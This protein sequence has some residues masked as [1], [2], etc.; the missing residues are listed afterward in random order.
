MA[1][2]A[3]WK[4]SIGFGMAH[5]PVKLMTATRDQEPKFKR[6]HAPTKSYPN[7]VQMVNGEIVPLAVMTSVYDTGTALVE[8]T[9]EDLLTVA[10]VSKR[11]MQVMEFVPRSNIDP[12]YIE[13]T[14]FLQSDDADYAFALMA[15]ALEKR[16]VAAIVRVMMRTKEYL[17]MIYVDRGTVRL[18]TMFYDAEIVADN[19]VYFS[20]C[21]SEIPALTDDAV[22]TA[23]ALVDAY[24]NDEFN[25]AKYKD[26]YSMRLL[27]MIEK[28]EAG[29]KVE[30]TMLP[31]APKGDIL[32]T[33]RTQLEAMREE[34]AA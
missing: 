19:G 27:E 16:D 23:C 2:K 6:W 29:V 5:V 13:K 34:V 20:G 17:A 4:G 8:I 30:P 9:K 12:L 18:S 26:V 24:F 31:K 22:D 1:G 3:I 14:Y 33:L 10:P 21:F 32:T 15:M 28:K 7:Q 11:H 25:A